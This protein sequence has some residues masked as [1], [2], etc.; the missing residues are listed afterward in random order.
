MK[1][2]F[3]RHAVSTAAYLTN[4]KGLFVHA[5]SCILW[6]CWSV[7]KDISFTGAEDHC[8]SLHIHIPSLSA[9]WRLLSNRVCPLCGSTKCIWRITTLR[10]QRVSFINRFLLCGLAWMFTVRQ[11]KEKN[12]ELRG[13]CF[14]LIKTCLC[15][16]TARWEKRSL[17]NA[18][19]FQTSYGQECWKL[20]LLSFMCC[21]TFIMFSCKEIP[22]LIK[23][24]LRQQRKH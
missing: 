17:Y 3:L 19:N 22:Q 7:Y 10:I 20:R 12:F 24:K 8:I 4:K 21:V 5:S 14:F 2:S 13:F 6:S 15:N 9:Q 11:P 23:W 16:F 18:M 1:S